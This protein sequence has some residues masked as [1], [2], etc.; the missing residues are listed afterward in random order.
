MARPWVEVVNNVQ[1][2]ANMNRNLVTLPIQARGAGNLGNSAT[3]QR[4]GMKTSQQGIPS[5]E[6]SHL[7]TKP[8]SPVDIEENIE[9]DNQKTELKKTCQ[10][11]RRKQSSSVVKKVLSLTSIEAR[12]DS[13]R[14]KV[15]EDEEVART[16][17]KKLRD[18]N[19]RSVLI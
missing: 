3:F 6:V 16:V 12:R 11:D 7:E 14:S 10:E 1:G 2:P 8:L 13:V 18:Q 19:S 15:D 17:V 4:L 5:L 9:D